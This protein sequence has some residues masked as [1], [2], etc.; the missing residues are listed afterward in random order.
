MNTEQQRIETYRNAPEA[1]RELYVSEALT[2]HID[3]LIETYKITLPFKDVSEIIGDTILGFYKISDLSRLFQEKLGLDTGQSQRMTSEL[4]EF[5]SPVVQREATNPKKESMAS[6]IE[7]FSKPAP[8]IAASEPVVEQQEDVAPLRTMQKDMNRIHGYGA[9]NDA[10]AQQETELQD[11]SVSSSQ[12][13]IL[14]N[15]KNP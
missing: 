8:I 1:I 2:Q 10:L 9:Y 7:T 14:N 12:E 5:L 4:I 6:L 13:G 3:K 15:G 11:S